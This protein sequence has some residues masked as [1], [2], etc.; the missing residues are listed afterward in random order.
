MGW[1]AGFGK[2][3]ITAWEPEL[4]MMG[5]GRPDNRIRGVHTPLYSRAA[6]FKSDETTI[7]YASLE[8]MAVSVGIRREVIARLAVDNPQIDEHHVMLTANHTHSG[9]NGYS[10]YFFMNLSGPGFSPKVFEA[11]VAGTVDAVK[12]ALKRLQPAEL[13]IGRADMPLD[14]PVAFNR[15]WFA[16]NLNEDVEPVPEDRR[17]EAVDR[18]MTLIAAYSVDGDALG[19]L[20]WF[21]VHCT[22]VHGENDQL[23]SDNKGLAAVAME[24]S[25][26][27]DF[28]AL[29]AQEAAGDVTP[30]Y[31]Y[32]R[33]R[34]KVIGHLA[35]DYES[36]EFNGDA[37]VRLAQDALSVAAAIGSNESFAAT[38]W[39]D[40]SGI[41]VSAKHARGATALTNPGVLGLSMSE[42]TAEG[43]G[44]M[45]GLKQFNRWLSRQKAR[46]KRSDDPKVPMLDVGAGLNG[47]FLGTF[48]LRAMRIPPLDPT[49]N[50]ISKVVKRGKMG[51]HPWFPQV[52]PIQLLQ[53]GP[54]AIVGLPFEITTVVGRRLRTHL[55]AALKDRGIEQVVVSSY[56]NG[57]AGYCT[58]FEEYQL[59]HYEAGYTLFGPHQLGAILTMLDWMVDRLDNMP[60]GASP[61]LFEKVDLQARS[62][63]EPWKAKQGAPPW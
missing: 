31:R 50:Y 38:H 22:S 45:L 26:G 9:P 28:V 4:S 1:S 60:T 43:P 11:A 53:I 27:G 2:S 54:I 8:L 14:A 23:H 13:K 32:D 34:K 37:Q 44:P 63:E 24:E 3:E 18:Q 51:E 7:I 57:Y 30:N 25:V 12:Q 5:W 20:N 6:V 10:E 56:S 35:N 47:R 42:G 16:Y 40:F 21:P 41:E 49:I 48:S 17:D 52:L 39:V 58:T 46:A 15:S 36:A 55:L 29:F 33:G 19:C 61:D 62:F 59:Q